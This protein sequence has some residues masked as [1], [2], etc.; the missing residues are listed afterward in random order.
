[1]YKTSLIILLAL[2]FYSCQDGE[3]EAPQTRNKAWWDLD[4]LSQR[5]KSNMDSASW[6]TQLFE[7]DIATYREYAEVFQS[8]PLN[9]SPFPVADYDYAVSSRPVLIETG[10]HIFKGVRIGEFKKVEDEEPLDRLTLLVMTDDKDSEQNTLVESRNYP[11]LTAQGF[12][13]TKDNKFDWV[14]SAS[15]DGYSTLM[16]NMKLFDLRFGET[17]VI[18]PRSGRAFVYD[19]IDDSPEN[20]QNF[21]DFKAAIESRL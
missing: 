4:S 8:F 2:T 1:M 14:F 9:K 10:E 5:A 7:Q 13:I 19:Q 3:T 20:Y 15:P 12:F 17:I 18:Y 16:V 11:Y 21:E 6:D